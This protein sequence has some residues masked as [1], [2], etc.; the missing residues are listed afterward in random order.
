MPHADS[1]YVPS[2]I[3]TRAQFWEHV[4]HQLEALISDQRNWVSNL[5]NAASLIYH[6]LLAFSPHFGVNERA[7]NWCGFYLDSK[8]FPGKQDRDS[9]PMLLLAPFAGKPACQFIHAKAGKGVCADAYVGRRPLSVPNVEEYP[10][11]IACDGDTKSELVIPLITET[12]SGDEIAL[13]VI[14]LDCVALE[15]FTHD[16]IEG[17][18]KIAN[19]I[20]S[21]CDWE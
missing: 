21:S 7:V 8:L 2:S 9:S 16:D 6:S 4:Y 20:V 10:G 15:G 11:H 13:G 12:S 19:L 1:S 14:D 17:L 3:T 18:Q 5:S